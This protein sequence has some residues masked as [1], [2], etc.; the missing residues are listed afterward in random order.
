MKFVKLLTTQGE[1]RVPGGKITFSIYELEMK[2]GIFFIT[3]LN[4][5]PAKNHSAMLL[6][7]SARQSKFL[8][9]IIMCLTVSLIRL[10]IRHLASAYST[11]MALSY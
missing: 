7:F 5:S 2:G 11:Q 10:W 6:S 3:L 8:L 1:G 9:Q 4:H